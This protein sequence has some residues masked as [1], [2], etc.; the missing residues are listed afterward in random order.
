MGRLPVARE[1]PGGGSGGEILQ[2][3]PEDLRRGLDHREAAWGGNAP[4]QIIEDARLISQGFPLPVAEVRR[5]E[6]VR[7]ENVAGRDFQP[8]GIA[9]DLEHDRPRMARAVAPRHAAEAVDAQ[10]ADIFDVIRQ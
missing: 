9:H 8:R 6:V 5:G 1:G 7:R 3:E 2:P 4:W 10:G